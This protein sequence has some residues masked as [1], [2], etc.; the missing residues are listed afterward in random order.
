M[1]TSAIISLPKDE[2]STGKDSVGRMTDI[3]KGLLVLVIAVVIGFQGMRMLDI[4]YLS[5]PSGSQASVKASLQDDDKLLAAMQAGADPTD[6]LPPTAA[7]KALIGHSGCE[8]GM[9]SGSIDDNRFSK[10][11]YAALSVEGVRY[12]QVSRFS[13]SYLMQERYQ[14]VSAVE[15]KDL[16]DSIK[17]Q[18]NSN[19]ESPAGCNQQDLYLSSIKYL[20]Q[21]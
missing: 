7:G 4:E 21:Q 10:I 12:I 13:P 1:I 5:Q 6:I 20:E 19:M 3:A 11:S 14:H 17:A 18:L 2:K 16:P 15:V 9:I 8:T